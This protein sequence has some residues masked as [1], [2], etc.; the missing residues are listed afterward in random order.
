LE[1][2]FFKIKNIIKE[3]ADAVAIQLDTDNKKFGYKAGQFITIVTKIDGKEIKRS[4]SLCSSP[5]EDGYPTFCVKSIQG[6]LMS[7]YLVKNLKIGDTLTI[8]GPMGNLK[9]EPSTAKKK[10]LFFAAGSGIT[11]MIAIIKNMLHATPDSRLVLVYGNRTEESII[12]KKELENLRSTYYDR[13]QIEYVLSNPPQNWLEHRGRINQGMAVQIAKKYFATDIANVDFYLCGPSGMM[14]EVTKGLEL[15]NVKHDNIHKESF[16]AKEL[17]PSAV[18]ATFNGNS[19][20]K[21]IDGKKTYEFEVAPNQTILETALK[22]G[23]GLPYSCQAGMCTACMGKCISGK[24]EMSESD[25]LTDG[26]IKQGYVLTCVGY[27]RSAE[28]VIEV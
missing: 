9:Y 24:V 28:V 5:T 22:L 26:E 4:Y 3:T 2:K 7:N 1:Q 19:K 18:S 11:P 8:E 10:A 14:D 13:F 27:A 6:G 21:I 15:I 25:G 20:V 23:Y 16:H 17:E 12:F